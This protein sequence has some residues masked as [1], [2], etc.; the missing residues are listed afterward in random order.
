MAIDL[1]G[2]K[3]RAKKEAIRF[4]GFQNFANKHD[5]KPAKVNHIKSLLRYGRLGR[6][7]SNIANAFTK[8]I[9]GVEYYFFDYEYTYYNGQFH[10]K[11]E[12]TVIIGIHQSKLPNFRMYPKNYLHHIWDAITFAKSKRFKGQEYLNSYVVKSKE[13][14][15]ILNSK[16][17]P[18]FKKLIIKDELVHLESNGNKLFFYRENQI[19]LPNSVHSSI[20]F[21]MKLVESLT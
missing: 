18:A 10:Q 9:N 11:I 3:K 14:R 8:R 1:F 17:K 5:W 21:F 15:K 12:Q 16:F 6:V 20:T 7:E 4:E 13:D 2:K 19:C